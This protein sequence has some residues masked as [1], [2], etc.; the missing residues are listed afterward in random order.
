MHQRLV[1]FGARAV[2]L[3][4]G[5]ALFARSVIETDE[6]CDPYQFETASLFAEIEKQANARLEWGFA[7]RGIWERAV[8]EGPS[9][10]RV[11]EQ[12][13]VINIEARR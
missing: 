3:G 4:N 2:R 12:L 1:Q 11:V 10:W 7:H 9:G 13:P 5:T 6:A 8:R